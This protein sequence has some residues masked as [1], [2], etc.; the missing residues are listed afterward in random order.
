MPQ[1]APGTADAEADIGDGTAGKRCA[2]I[3]KRGIAKLSKVGSV[4]NYVKGRDK[5][6][7]L[8]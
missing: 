6:S 3:L 4:P 5:L 2:R 7:T 8:T 1:A